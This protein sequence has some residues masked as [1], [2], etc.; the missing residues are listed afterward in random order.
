M[1]MR[2]QWTLVAAV[3]ALAFLGAGRLDA[4]GRHLERKGFFIGG[5]MGYGGLDI[6]C[7]G[8][9][10][11]REGS[12][13]GFFHLGGAVSPQLLLGAE[14]NGWYKSLSGTSV[15][16]GTLT[17]T[18]IGYP[19]K[20]ANFFVRGGVGAGVLS[21][22]AGALGSD[23]ETGFG[24]SLGLGYDLPIGGRTAITPFTNYFLGTFSGGGANTIQV[25]LG[26]NAY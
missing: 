9:D 4:Q 16:M 6:T 21:A 10:V 13:S 1:R 25:G 17:F 23:S 12:V 26:I 20:A 24:A 3:A 2:C 8:C 14:T 11:S 15:T 22:D 19:S 7:G 5:G 18:A